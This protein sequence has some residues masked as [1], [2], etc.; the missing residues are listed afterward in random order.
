MK[1]NNT[2]MQCKVLLI[3]LLMAFYSTAAIIVV[4]DDGDSG[5]LEN[6]CGLRD[7]LLA[8]SVNVSVDGCIAGDAGIQDVIIIQV[9]GPIQLESN[10]IP[11][12]D[13]VT[14]S[15]NLGASRVK[16]LA[17]PNK[18][19][20]NVSAVSN[21]EL[22]LSMANL[23]LV[24]G[25]AEDEGGG[26]V[27]FFRNGGSFKD[28]EFRSMV[29]E[30]N[31]AASGGAIGLDE[32]SAESLLITDSIQ[33]SNNLFQ[34]NHSFGSGGAIFFDNPGNLSALLNNNY[35]IGNSA[36]SHGGA[37]MLSSFG[38]LQS[39]VYNINKNLFMFNQ[40]GA[41]GGAL[42]VTTGALVQLN[43]SILAYNLAVE[44]GGAIY[45]LRSNSKRDN[46]V[47]LLQSTVVHNQAPLGDNL[48]LSGTR[49]LARRSI[50]AYPVNGDNCSGVRNPISDRSFNNMVDDETCELLNDE[51]LTRISDPQLSGFTDDLAY[52]PGF[53][54]TVNSPAL[55]IGSDLVTTD[56]NGNDSPMDG[57]GENRPFSDL[58]AHEAPTNTDL[59]WRDNF[60]FNFGRVK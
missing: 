48:S 29:F 7:A 52:F 6:N 30:N 2:H 59:I 41:G 44:R 49:F 5:E 3:S 32:T 14:V 57:T 54:P 55:D 42:Y 20:F 58:G 51:S 25:D 35:F 16:I 45:A 11:I 19:I 26:A 22:S 21:R 8:A 47:S 46:N 15:T 36:E 53:Q 9:P 39:V 18:R 23:E 27:Y 60:G 33:V 17:A 37:L 31:N 43:Y 12:F 28:I 24:G 13:S 10:S 34:N 56:F 4:D 1:K 40:A 38:L 50:I